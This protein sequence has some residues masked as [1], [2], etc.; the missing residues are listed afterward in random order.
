MNDEEKTEPE[1]SARDN[2]L[3]LFDRW[4]DRWPNMFGG[5][6]PDLWGESLR[7]EEFVD[8]DTLVIRSEIPGV[9]PDDDIE[10][11]VDRGRLS[12]KARREQKTETKDDRS[13]RSEFHYGSFRRTVDLPP[14]TDPD[15]VKATYV[16]GILEVRVP[17]ASE[18]T[19]GTR[20]AVESG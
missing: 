1:A 5:H 3:A 8:D 19:T 13:F 16:D 7:V 12:I 15:D 11:D 9:N 18:G 10:I 14:G 20:V 2:R 6:M 4:V 17:Q